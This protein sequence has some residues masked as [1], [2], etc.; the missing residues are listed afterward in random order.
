MRRLPFIY[1]FIACS[2]NRNIDT[3]ILVYL[4]IQSAH[5]DRQT[6]RRTDGLIAKAYTLKAPEYRGPY[7]NNV[8]AKFSISVEC[9]LSFL[10]VS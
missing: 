5:A 10:C 4:E 3:E 9:S 7:N 8:Y 1:Y 2:G 6:D